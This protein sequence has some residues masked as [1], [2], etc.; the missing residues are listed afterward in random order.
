VTTEA[1]DTDR[2]RGDEERVAP[3]RAL[4]MSIGC[5]MAAA[6]VSLG[7]RDVVSQ[8]SSIVWILALVPVFMLSYYKGWRGAAVAAGGAMVILAGV[9]VFVIRFAGNEID[10]WVLAAPTLLLIPVTIGSGALSELLHRQRTLALRMAYRDPMTG[11]ANRRLLTELAE[12]AMATARREA[13]GFAVLFLDVVR[14]KRINDSLGHAAGDQVL[15]QL[16]TRLEDSFRGSD[17]VARVGGDE[18]VV[19]LPGVSTSEDAIAAAGRVRQALS[20][21]F[22]VRGQSLRLNA[23]LGVSLFPEHGESFDELLTH[24]DPVR[25]GAGKPD[26]AEIV[27]FDPAA[28][29]ESSNPLLL[30]EDLEKAIDDG[31][32][33]VVYQPIFDLERGTIAG[34]EALAR[35][36]DPKLGV[37]QAGD[38]IALAEASGL[39]LRLEREVLDL[40]IAQA[41]RWGAAG[42]PLWVSVNLSPA[43]FET[44]GFVAQ[45]RQLVSRAEVDP[46]RIVLE[47]TE[48]A[49][50]RS[51]RGVS[52]VIKE[53]GQLGVR[54]ALDDFGTGLSS[55]AYIGD[56]AADFLKVDRVFATQLGDDP[57]H[58]RLVEGILGLG[59]GLN[60]AV[61]AEGVERKEQLEWFRARGCDFVQGYYT[62]RP[63]T[64]EDLTAALSAGACL[65]TIESD[66]T[67]L[68]RQATVSG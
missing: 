12:K 46:Q 54:L 26:G 6:L 29:A 42:W 27:I 24:A 68:A 51:R 32:V 55:L 47:L 2:R 11:V 52:G 18:F 62:G 56:F 53:L 25:M 7:A 48:R 59:R 17:I 39:I 3:P 36:K 33:F 38:F 45:L 10:W 9:E 23:R 67:A 58:E 1:V 13:S 43:S 21:P 65:D 41:R 57:R 50:A 19:C 61:I 49:A 35:L 66:T 31:K 14:F 30:E 4:G 64:A 5:L 22:R 37:I 40:S 60:M 28:A 20:Y 44:P 15:K 34:A 16:A 63:M 8:Y